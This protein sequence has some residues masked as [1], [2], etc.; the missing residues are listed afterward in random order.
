VRR[1]AIVQAR[2]GSTRLPGKVLR[3]L[4]GA[5]MLEQQIRRMRRAKTLDAIG[6]AT[7]IDPRDDAVAALARALDIPF[8]R[9]SEHDLLDR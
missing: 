2:M 6:I 7:T 9:G 5:P 1:V 3:D 8:I 4:A